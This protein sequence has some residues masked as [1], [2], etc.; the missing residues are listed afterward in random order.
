MQVHVHAV[1][2]ARLV[3]LAEGSSQ[4]PAGR[5]AG[6]ALK[7]SHQSGAA[8]AMQLAFTVR[9]QHARL[10]RHEVSRQLRHLVRC[11]QVELRVWRASP[12]GLA[13]IASRCRGI[14]PRGHGWVAQQMQKLRILGIGLLLLLV[15]LL[16]QRVLQ[17]QLLHLCLVLL[18]QRLLHVAR[19][20]VGLVLAARTVASQLHV[21]QR[22]RQRSRSLGAGS[23]A[24]TGRCVQ[25]A[26]AHHVG[27]QVARRCSGRPLQVRQLSKVDAV[28]LL[29][30]VWAVVRVERLQAVCARRVHRAARMAYAPAAA[31]ARLVPAACRPWH[32]QRAGLARLVLPAVMREARKGRVAVNGQG[33]SAAAGLPLE[34]FWERGVGGHAHGRGSGGRG[35]GCLS[36]RHDFDA[37]L[38]Q[39]VWGVRKETYLARTLDAVV[40]HLRAVPACHNK[41]RSKEHMW[42][43]GLWHRVPTVYKPATE[44][45]KEWEGGTCH[46]SNKR[47]GWTERVGG[48]YPLRQ[49]V[50]AKAVEHFEQSILHT[51]VLVSVAHSCMKFWPTQAQACQMAF[52]RG[53]FDCWKA[54]APRK[55]SQEG[56]LL[57]LT[58]LAATP[59]TSLWQVS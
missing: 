58:P 3:D 11:P 41:R 14:Y 45:V 38:P 6:R 26:R 31:D 10:C 9:D 22:C 12:V 7:R 55:A 29:E 43:R 28:A 51:A 54:C 48:W 46:T 5:S 2:S 4:L 32:H 27:W 40:A 39:L 21:Q 18:H 57:P 15:L 20:A 30:A 8:A 17:Q 23:V 49:A 50:R 25:H 53:C 44:W 37:R 13:A 16:Q 59:L 34:G 33:V 24:A 36:R 35:L 56:R 52:L 1:G 19:R 42:V 47:D